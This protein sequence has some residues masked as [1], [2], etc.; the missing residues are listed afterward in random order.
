MAQKQAIYDRVTALVKS[1]HGADISQVVT[2]PLIVQ[3]RTQQADLIRQEAQ[4]ASRY[5]P[6][7]PKMIDIESQRHNLEDKIAQEVTRIVGT[8]ANDVAI[9][10]AQVK[11]L[12]SN[13]KQSEGQASGQNMTRVKLKALQVNAISTRSM[14]ESFVTR[15]RE[16]QNQEAIQVPDAH[17]ISRALVPVAPTSPHRILIF[18][19]SIPA[20]LLFGLFIALLVERFGPAFRRKAVQLFR[21]L[22]VLAKIP[23]SDVRYAADQPLSAF[24]EAV[25]G[26]VAKLAS[27]GSGQGARV[28]AVTSAEAGEGKTAIAVGLARAAAKRGFRT[29]ILDGNLQWPELARTLGIFLRAEWRIRGSDWRRTLKP[30]AI[31]GS[32]L[33]STYTFHH[34]A[35][36]Q[37]F[38]IAGIKRHGS[39]RR[40]SAPD[41]RS[42]D[43]RFPARARR[44]RNALC[45][46]AWPMR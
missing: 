38:A 20:G 39:S 22:P 19:A 9:A 29:I 33:D 16:T 28:I 8:V 12:E 2:S 10:R 44:I 6:L 18:C 37:F 13:L 5:G 41:L 24:S 1:G 30:R 27:L 21:G 7:H 3:L 31:Q 15:L 35:R 4:L 40:T 17:V 36:G 23:D 46:P 26:L 45:C 42:R 14:Y 32:T 34:T 43:H 11:A 25:D